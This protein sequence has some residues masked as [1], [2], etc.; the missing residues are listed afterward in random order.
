MPGTVV[1]RRRCSAYHASHA[2]SR[3]GSVKPLWLMKITAVGSARDDGQQHVRGRALIVEDGLPRGLPAVPRGLVF[4][5]VQ[6]AIEAREVARRDFDPD[7]MTGKEHVARR[8]E[9]DRE[10]RDRA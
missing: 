10:A 6:I 3:A 9:I 8:P 1:M 4:P 7:A 5:R 2:D